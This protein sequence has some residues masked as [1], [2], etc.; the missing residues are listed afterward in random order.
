MQ[1]SEASS[2]DGEGPGRT[3]WGRLSF[4]CRCWSEGEGLSE[5]GFQIA[6]H[7]VAVGKKVGRVQIKTRRDIGEQ[8]VSLS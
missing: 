7:E 2:A 6:K 1:G 8:C 4:H 3:A 5:R